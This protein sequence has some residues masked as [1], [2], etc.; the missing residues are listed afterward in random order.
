VLTPWR[1]SAVTDVGHRSAIRQERRATTAKSWNEFAHD[2]RF[3]AGGRI[4][5]PLILTM[6]SGKHGYEK[7]V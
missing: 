5:R 2:R 1:N 6:V 7:V 3:L 4:G